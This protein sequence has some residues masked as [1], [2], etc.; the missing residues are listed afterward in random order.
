[1]LLGTVAKAGVQT[2]LFGFAEDY[3]K[4]QSLMT[5]M[6]ERN[7]KYSRRKIRSGADVMHRFGA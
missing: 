5:V 4:S 2:D 3:P 1:M 6:D 7:K